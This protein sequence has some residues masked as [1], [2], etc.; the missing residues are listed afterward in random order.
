MKKHIHCRDCEYAKLDKKASEY[1]KKRCKS[2]DKWES[3]PVCFGCKEK[4]NCKA[5]HSRNKPQYCD[6]RLD[7]VCPQ[8]KVVWAAYQCTNSGSEYF[9]ALLNVSRNG[10]M[11]DEITWRGCPEGEVYI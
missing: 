3:C 6:R 4:S 11:Q 8:Q 7:T 1:T 5:V 9:R 2:C 10:D